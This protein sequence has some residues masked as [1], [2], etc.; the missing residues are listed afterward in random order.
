[1]PCATN[2]CSPASS[3]SP[4]ASRSGWLAA[5]CASWKEKSAYEPDQRR[6]E[7]GESNTDADDT[8]ANEGT[9]A[10][11]DTHASAPVAAVCRSAPGRNCFRDGHVYGYARLAKLAHGFSKGNQGR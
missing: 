4:S 3:S 8:G 2:A 9:L 11:G 6:P 10:R 7:K 5:P 1:M